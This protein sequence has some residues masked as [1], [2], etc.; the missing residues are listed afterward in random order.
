MLLTLVG[1]SLF[2]LLTARVA[3]FLVEE[4]ERRADGAKLDELLQ[5]VRRLEERLQADRDGA[6]PGP[7]VL[8][9]AGPGASTPRDV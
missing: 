9:T 3:A 2:G 8:T 1:I 5:R 4:E 6:G 7:S